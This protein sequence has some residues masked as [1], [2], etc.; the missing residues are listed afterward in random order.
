MHPDVKA[1]EVSKDQ[2]LDEEESMLRRIEQLITSSSHFSLVPLSSSDP[3][4]DLSTG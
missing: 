1:T 2:E 3:A 4:Q